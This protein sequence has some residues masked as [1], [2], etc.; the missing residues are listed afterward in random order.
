VCDLEA[1]G[2]CRAF[3]KKR[4]AV[5]PCVLNAAQYGATG[6]RINYMQKNQLL[7]PHINTNHI[8]LGL[9]KLHCRHLQQGA[10]GYC[11][12]CLIIFP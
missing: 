10:L 12:H 11:D 8:R 1:G 3:K 9:G 6:K 4:Q 2:E 7:S 5:M